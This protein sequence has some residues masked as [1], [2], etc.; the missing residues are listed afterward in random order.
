MQLKEIYVFML[1][2]ETTSFTD[3]R[4]VILVPATAAGQHPPE[5]ALRKLTL[6]HRE[7]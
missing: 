1:R 5:T 7:S 4:G 6:P 2:T 3:S